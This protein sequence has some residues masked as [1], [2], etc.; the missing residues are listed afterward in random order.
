MNLGRLCFLLLFNGFDMDG[1]LASIHLLNLELYGLV[2]GQRAKT[3][4]LDSRVV[5]KD[6][7]AILANQEAKSLFAV[8]PFYCSGHSFFYLVIVFC[9][10]VLT[11]V[12][13]FLGETKLFGSFFD[14]FQ[15]KIYLC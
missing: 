2:L 1:L 9:V 12:S 11:K 7:F 8:E 3:F 4:G 13:H 5:D 14:F 15:K 6:L 10:I